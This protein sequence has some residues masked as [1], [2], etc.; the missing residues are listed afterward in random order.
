MRHLGALGCT[1]A[2]PGPSRAGGRTICPFGHVAGPGRA[3]GPTERIPSETAILQPR[4]GMLGFE[5]YILT[6][7]FQT[8]RQHIYAIV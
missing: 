2:G 3:D 4:S 8:Y 7:I 5:K 6:Y 1:V